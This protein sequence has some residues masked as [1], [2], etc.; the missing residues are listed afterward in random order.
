MGAQ[1]AAC[2]ALTHLICMIGAFMCDWRKEFFSRDS[3]KK[4]KEV[5]GAVDIFT[6]SSYHMQHENKY[7]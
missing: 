4:S 6:E 5:N 3:C 7:H 1:H 2:C